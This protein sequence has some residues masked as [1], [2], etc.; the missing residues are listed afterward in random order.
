MTF[1]TNIQSFFIASKYYMA[2]PFL[3][4]QLHLTQTYSRLCPI[5]HTLYVHHTV[6]CLLAFNHDIHRSEMHLR[7]S[8]FL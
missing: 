8:L 1:R 3:L 7:Y 2:A 5:T 4:A 6:S